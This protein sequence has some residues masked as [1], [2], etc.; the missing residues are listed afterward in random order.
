MLT[1]TDTTITTPHGNLFSRRWQPHTNQEQTILLFHDSLGCVELWR[2]FPAQ[3]AHATNL[4]VIAYDR[5]GFG[6]S[7]PSPTPLPLTFIRDEATHTIPHIIAQLHLTKL[8]LFGH[9]VGGAMA[10]ATAAQHPSIC[11]ALITES[12]QSF[13]EDPT[14]AGVRAG[15]KEFSHPDRFARLQKYH[16]AKAQ[17][18]LDSWT[19]TWLSFDYANWTLDED[20]RGVRCPTLAIHGDRDEY[21]TIEHAN[22]IARLTSGPSRTLILPGFGHIPHRQDPER[23]FTELKTFLAQSGDPSSNLSLTNQ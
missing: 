16:G 12:A 20:L 1:T 4:P 18:V 14:L 23:I 21:G 5:L 8:I 13:V 19:K 17:W 9:S 10:V 15:E 3:L 7:S 11:T 22:R 2:N 6:R